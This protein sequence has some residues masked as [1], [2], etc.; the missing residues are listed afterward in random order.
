MSNEKIIKKFKFPIDL[1]EF[2]IKYSKEAITKKDDEGKSTLEVYLKGRYGP[3]HIE[4]PR[5]YKLMDIRTLLA[6]LYFT[7]YHKERIYTERFTNWLDLLEVED[8]GFYRKAILNG[9]DYLERTIFY[10]PYIYDTEKQLRNSS[11]NF[12]DKGE[13]DWKNLPSFSV[14]RILDSYHHLSEEKKRKSEIKVILGTDFYER[15]F[16][17]KYFSLIDFKKV[18]PLKDISLNLYLFVHRQDPKYIEKFP[19]IFEDLKAHIG[20]TTKNITRARQIF[21]KAWQDIKDARLLLNYKYELKEKENL[22][23]FYIKKSLE[24]SVDN[25]KQA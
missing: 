3:Y 18:I 12:T 4:T 17:D 8:T 22:I 19:V 15:I 24:K 11:F 13:I 14:W 2:P 20:I 9:L 16:K 23:W 7:D 1:I 10:T 6:N 5:K 25:F 21:E